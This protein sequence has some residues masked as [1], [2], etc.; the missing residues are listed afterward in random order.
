MSTVGYG[1]ITPYTV[2]E[3]IYAMLTM[4]MASGV[5]AFTIGSIGSLISKANAVENEY[6][7]QVVAVNRYMKRKKLPS[8]LQF[9][10]RRYLDYL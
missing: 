5:F 10:V 1:D 3:K 2:V 7:E 9:R 6:R 4:I 8:D